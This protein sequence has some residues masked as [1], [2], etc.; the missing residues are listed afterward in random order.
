MMRFSEDMVPARE[1]AVRKL[2]RMRP[3]MSQASCSVDFWMY[4][5]KNE[6]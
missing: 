2:V 6:S 1:R 4:A 5:W 3:L